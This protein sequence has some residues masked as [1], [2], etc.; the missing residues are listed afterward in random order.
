VRFDDTLDTV[1]AGGLDTPLAAQSGWRQIVDLVGR[2][3]IEPDARAMATLAGL[4][5]RVPLAVRVASAR[6][7]IGSRPPAALIR[8]FACDEIAVAAP[9]LRFAQ[10]PGP[11]W[12]ALLPELSPQARAVLRHRR[13][14]DAA[15]MRALESF[16]SV[17][18]VLPA[19]EASAPVPDAA[20]APAPA[21]D[22]LDLATVA[23][24]PP[25]PDPFRSLG[26][27]A[28]DLPLVAEALRQGGGEPGETYRIADVVARIE[29]YQRDHE[30]TPPS[31][32]TTAPAAS[33]DLFTFD[34]DAAGTIRA[35]DGVA[36]GA[37]VGLSLAHAASPG[38]HG[39]DAAAAAAFGRRTRFA[40]AQ[41]RVAGASDAAGEW[42][43]SGTPAFDPRTGRFTGYR[44]HARRPRADERPGRPPAPDSMRQ[45]VHELRT[46]TNAIIG[47]SEMI[48]HA[49]LG[50]VPEP[51]REQARAIRGDAQALL[52]A[53]DDLDTA[54]RIQS[55]ALDLR[56][57]HVVLLPLLARVAGDLAPLA[58][59]RG[60]RL[61]IAGD[62][63]EAFGDAR[64]VHRILERLVAAM[65]GLA[66]RGETIAIR[67][68][69]RD[70]LTIA[71]PRALADL[72]AEALLAIDD[73]ANPGSLLGTGFALRL[74]RNL[75]RE[76]GGS[77]TI[78]G[79]AL[80]LR[81]P[82]AGGDAMEQVR[83]S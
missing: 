59:L 60:A 53:I 6:A 81:L 35:V 58:E 82:A 46:P 65:L 14:L 24:V 7:M 21:E 19:G 66:G 2:G 31:A 44:G 61:E 43:L 38:G 49:M 77:L 25:P 67:G 76:V 50:P 34:A 16:G 45:L 41:L 8:L 57:E 26:E 72:D 63:G 48:E 47:F 55:G 83:L 3:R 74:V 73:P 18:F 23:V 68:G 15:T 64:T 30:G 40:D 79:D 39:V 37:L 9:V 29:A 54:A 78:G 75:A 71:R 4:Q 70:T 52:A 12:T 56:P 20:P 13:D 51:Y 10:L 27:V 32:A 69:D 33:G 1:L 22:E 11:E 28:N 17:D 5:G 62:P 42:R 36:R 80:T